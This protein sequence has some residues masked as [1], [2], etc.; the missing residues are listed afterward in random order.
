[1]H[2]DVEPF[3]A[4][5]AA[6]CKNVG[7]EGPV[8]LSYPAGPGDSEITSCDCHWIASVSQGESDS[9]CA[10]IVKPCGIPC[11][12]ESQELAEKEQT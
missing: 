7:L 9:M 1:M 2:G 3:A 12:D 5:L 8:V 11:G 6:A 4:K 10:Q